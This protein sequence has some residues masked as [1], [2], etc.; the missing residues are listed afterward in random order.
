MLD[1]PPNHVVHEMYGE[2]WDSLL[3]GL[4]YKTDVDIWTGNGNRWPIREGD[5]WVPVEPELIEP[6]PVVEPEPEPNLLLQRH[7]DLQEIDMF[8]YCYYAYLF[9]GMVWTTINYM[10]I[11]DT[12]EGSNVGFFTA[13]F[14]N[15]FIWPAA[16]GFCIYK[17]CRKDQTQNSSQNAL[18][19]PNAT[20]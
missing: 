7:L 20:T 12:A 2:T 18:T 15:T 1:F 16:V 6:E 8:V 19:R 11:R 4:Q 13:L 17:R 10:K 5:S 9:I 3:T 14:L